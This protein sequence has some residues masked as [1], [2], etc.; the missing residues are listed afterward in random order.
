VKYLD[1]GFPVARVRCEVSAVQAGTRT[2]IGSGVSQ[3]D[4][5][6]DTGDLPVSMTE[7]AITV[8]AGNDPH[9]ADRYRCQLYLAPRAMGEVAVD[10]TNQ[11]FNVMVSDAVGVD[12]FRTGARRDAWVRDMTK[13]CRS[14]VE[15]P[16]PRP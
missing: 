10:C 4:A 11:S 9:S 8:A 3:I 15:G 14:T 16:V 6:A 1:E 5:N 2:V 13:P 12:A 7:V